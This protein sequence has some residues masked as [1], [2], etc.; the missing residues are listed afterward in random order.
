[1][2]EC[3]WDRALTETRSHKSTFR[4]VVRFI[5]ALMLVKKNVDNKRQTQPEVGRV[6]PLGLRKCN[7]NTERR[8]G[9]AKEEQCV[10]EMVTIIT[11]VL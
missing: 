11:V 7:S 6:R 2:K 1:M 4:V 5:L 9:A 10:S 3:T 8:N